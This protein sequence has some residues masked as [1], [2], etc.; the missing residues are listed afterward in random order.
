MKKKKIII[1]VIVIL[2][3]IVLLVAG[4]VISKLRKLDYNEGIVSEEVV[5]EEIE[6]EI[7]V[8]DEE[9]EIL[10]EAEVIL[11]EEEVQSDE[12]VYNILLL[13]T[14]EKTSKFSTNARADS[15]IILSL[16]KRDNTV[17]LV[18]LQR[19]MGVPILE[20]QYEGEYDWI[21]HMFRY[22]G[23]DLM[24]RTIN[25]VLNVEVEHYVRV[26]P[27]TFRALID[28]IGGTDIVLTAEEAK[29][30]NLAGQA[31]SKMQTVYEGLNHLDGYNTFAYTRLRSIDSDWKR[32]ERQRTVIQSLMTSAKDMTLKDLNNMLDTVLPLVQTNLTTMD[33]LGLIT[34]A[35]A[36]LGMEME[37]MTIPVKGTYGSMTG[38]GG[39]KLYAV[40]FQENSK[41]LHEFLY[42]VED[43]AEEGAEI[44]EGTD[45]AAGTSADAGAESQSTSQ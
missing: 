29:A 1:S 31:Y 23:A 7:L 18:S 11:S 43:E 32:V 14:D 30:I 45:A 17:K 33:I 24:L 38:L 2:L 12:D 10:G 36:V 8:T 40:D 19:G 37:Q 16:N 42:G 34:Y 22:G 28:A 4:F 3:L 13:G 25:E 6:E 44:V 9:A 41:I 26:N 15:I 27:N 21:T 20:G 5:T 35:P 39:R